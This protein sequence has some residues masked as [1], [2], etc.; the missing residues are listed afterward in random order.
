MAK[1][2]KVFRYRTT[3]TEEQWRELSQDLTSLSDE[4]FKI[5]YEFSKSG[6][7]KYHDEHFGILSPITPGTIPYVA[8]SGYVKMTIQISVEAKAD[9]DELLNQL[10]QQTGLQRRYQTSYL[11]TQQVHAF[12]K[13]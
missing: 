12:R 3:A 11:I 10:E 9:L 5:K 6:I 7:R 2:T 4:E 1:M 8:P 13:Q